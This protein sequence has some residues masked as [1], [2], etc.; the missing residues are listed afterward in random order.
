[1]SVWLS[2]TVQQRA[3]LMGLI[4]VL[5]MV[6]C[7]GLIILPVFAKYHSRPIIELLLFFCPAVVHAVDD[8]LR[9]LVKTQAVHACLS[10]SS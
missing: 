8:V 7:F 6:L 3:N 9:C 1:M 4:T 10:L 5:I 2:I